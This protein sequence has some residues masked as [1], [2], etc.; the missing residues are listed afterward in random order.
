METRTP[1]SP[2]QFERGL[3]IGKFLP[4]HLGHLFLIESALNRCKYLTVLLQSLSGDEIPGHARWNWLRDSFPSRDF[5]DVRIVHAAEDVPQFPHEHADFWA[6]WRDLILRQVGPCDAVFSSEDYG[7]TLSQVLGARHVMVD[8]ERLAVPI[9]GTKLRSDAFAH[10]EFLAPQARPYFARRVLIFG[11]ESTGKTTLAEQ[12]AE[13]FNTSWVAEWARELVAAKDNVVEEADIPA[14]VAGQCEREEEATLRCNKLLFCDTDVVTTT[15][16]ARHFYGRCAPWVQ[17]AADERI[18]RYDLILFCD[19]D[20]PWQSDPQRDPRHAEPEFRAYFRD[21]FE[22]EL[23]SRRL[24][25]KV[26]RGVGE[27]RVE[28]AA[29]FVEEMMRASST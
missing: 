28:N 23:L 6:I 13:R 4:L 5:P 8:R 11:P 21:L 10:W 26:V 1:P 12:L 18:G 15:V 25:Y 22:A 17:R 16:Y 3:I 9:S 29:R 19:T 2:S 24:R 14:I 20:I 7:A 27:D